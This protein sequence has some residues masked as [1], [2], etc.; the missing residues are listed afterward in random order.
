MLANSWAVG[1]AIFTSA[2]QLACQAQRNACARSYEEAHC[3]TY[4]YW[5]LHK[6]IN[7][8]EITEADYE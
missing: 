4:E 6:S 8:A 7:T 3:Q 1:L 5:D 2:I